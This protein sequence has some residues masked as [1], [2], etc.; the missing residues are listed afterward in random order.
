MVGFSVVSGVIGIAGTIYSVVRGETGSALS[1]SNAQLSN[2]IAEG[3]ESLEAG[4][5][6]LASDLDNLGQAEIATALRDVQDVA[7]ALAGLSG[8]PS[9][10]REDVVTDSRTALSNLLTQVNNFVTGAGERP[11][12]DNT[13][14][15]LV[16]V[17]YAATVHLEVVRLLDNSRY[18]LPANKELFGL[19]SQFFDPEGTDISAAVDVDN[20]D[21]TPDVNF[22]IDRNI[23]T[24][25]LEAIEREIDENLSVS[26]N[27]TDGD[28]GDHEYDNFQR[29]DNISAADDKDLAFSG[30][31]EYRSSP[32]ITGIESETYDEFVLIQ[33]DKKVFVEIGAMYH[34]L[35]IAEISAFFDANP[36]RPIAGS[37]DQPGSLRELV[38]IYRDGV[39]AGRPP[40]FS[41]RNALEVGDNIALAS[42]NL[43]QGPL[44]PS[45]AREIQ[46][47]SIIQQEELRILTEIFGPQDYSEFGNFAGLAAYFEEPGFEQLARLSEIYADLSD[48]E[49]VARSDGSQPDINGTDGNDYLV[50]DDLTTDDGAD[51]TLTGGAGEDALDAG[52]GNDDLSGEA[53]SD[54]LGGGTGSD[55]LFGGPGN[56]T[57]DGGPGSDTL[58]GGPGFDTAVLEAPLRAF[59]FVYAD[60]AIRE[61][62]VARAVDVG[63]PPAPMPPGDGDAEPTVTIF[64]TAYAEEDSTDGAFTV[65]LSEALDGPVEIGIDVANARDGAEFAASGADYTTLE[66]T[67][68]IPAGEVSAT[69]P[70]EV[71]ADQEPEA[72][73]EVQVTLDQVRSGGA[74]I[75]SAD[76]ATVL[77]G[78]D[79]LRPTELTSIEA[80]IFNGGEALIPVLRYLDGISLLEADSFLTAADDSLEGTADGEVLAGG[81]GRDTLDG[82]G[83]DDTLEGGTEDDE[84]DGGE[85]DDSLLGE[86]GDDSLTGGEGDDTLVPGPGDDVIAARGD[87]DALIR[88]DPGTDTVRLSGLPSDYTYL[89]ATNAALADAPDTDRFVLW[90]DGPDGQ[91]R[92]T[93]VERLVFTGNATVGDTD[94]DIAVDL[95]FRKLAGPDSLTGS[96]DADLIFGINADTTLEGGAGADTIFGSRFIDGTDIADETAD[97]IRGGAGNDLLI[98]G[99][100]GVSDP[101]GSDTIEG[102]TGEDTIDGGGGGDLLRGGE[103]ADLIDG[104]GSNDTLEGGAGNDTL[105]GGA[106]ADSLF[107]GAGDDVLEAAVGASE[108][109]GDPGEGLEGGAGNDTLTGSAGDDTLAGDDPDDPG[110]VK[111]DDR[112]FGGDGLDAAVFSGAPGDYAI[113]IMLGPEEEGGDP[114]RIE[115]TGAGTDTLESVETLIFQ[116]QGD[117]DGPVVIDDIAAVADTVSTAS[118][119]ISPLDAARAEGDEESSGFTFEVERGGNLLSSVNIG[120]DVDLAF[121]DVDRGDFVEGATSGRL[122]FDPGE[123]RKMVTIGVAA[124]RTEEND[125]FFEVSLRDPQ[126]NAE[127]GEGAAQGVILNDDG[128]LGTE[129]SVSGP[130]NR[131]EGDT[132]TEEFVFFVTRSGGTAQ[133]ATVDWS[134]PADAVDAADFGGTLP[135][136]T[137]TFVPGDEAETI[138]FDVAGDETPE[139]NEP[140]EVVLSNPSSGVRIGE[141]SA[142]G[143]II[144]DDGGS[145]SGADTQL[146]IAPEDAVRMEGNT[147]TTPF[148]FTVSRSGDTAGETSVDYAVSGFAPNDDDADAADFP[149]GVLPSGT[150]TFADDETEKTV[151]I[152][153]A[154]DTD[155]EEDETFVVNLSN[156]SAGTEIAGD[157]A[158]GTILDEDG[159]PPAEIAIIEFSSFEPEEGDAGTTEVTFVVQRSGTRDGEVSVDYA[160]AGGDVDAADFVGGRLPTGTLTFEDGGDLTKVFTVDVAGDITVEP[161]EDLTVVLSNPE[162]NA[163]ITRASRTKPLLNDDGGSGTPGEL[164]EGGP[165]GESLPGGDGDDTI[166]ARG[167]DDILDGGAGEDSMDGGDGFDTVVLEESL[168]DYDFAYSD[169]ARALVAEGPDETDLLDRVEEIVFD[170]GAGTEPVTRLVAAET[171]L[172]RPFQAG[173]DI[174]EV[175]FGAPGDD[176]SIL[177]TLGG[178]D[179]LDGRGGDDV[180]DGGQGEDELIGG[181]GNDILY[182]GEDADTFTVRPGDG[183]S[184]ILDFEDGVDLL[185]LTAF[186]QAEVSAV[187]DDIA[188]P[189]ATLTFLD[190]TTIRLD[191]LDPEDLGPEDLVSRAAPS[192]AELS[193]AAEA[194]EREEGDAGTTGFTFTV[195]RSGDTTG[196][197]SVD[198]AVGGAAVDGSDFD[199]GALPS[200]TVT[201]A[202]GETERSLTVAVAGDT[203]EEADEAFT[204]TL[205]NPSGAATIATA[206]ATGVIAN[207]DVE[208]DELSDRILRGTPRPDLQLGTAGATLLPD[209]GEDILLISDAAEPGILSVFEGQEGD[210]IQL[211]GGLEIASSL[212]VSNALQIE[213]TNGAR[214]QILEADQ[215]AYEIGANAVRNEAGR[216]VDIATFAQDLLGFA[217]SGTDLVEG[218]AVTVPQPTGLETDT[219]VTPPADT[220]GVLRGTDVADVLA[221]RSGTIYLGEDGDDTFI[222]SKAV[223]PGETSVIDGEAGDEVELI[224][225]LVIESA[226]VLPD[227]IELRLDSGAA[228]QILNANGLSYDIGGDS[229]RPVEGQVI[230]YRSFV[231]DV[232]RVDLP[233]SGSVIAGPVTIGAATLLLS[234][235]SGAEG[236]PGAP[237]GVVFTLALDQPALRDTTFAVA[238]ADGT[239]IAGEDYVAVDTTATIAAGETTVEVSVPF[240]GDTSVE[241]DETFDFVISSPGAPELGSV[242]LIGTIE[243]DDFVAV[244]VSDASVT[245]GAAGARLDFTVSLD[246]AAPEPVEVPVATADG[247]ATAGE[248]YT[249]LDTVVTIPAGQTSAAVSVEVL[250]D[251]LEEPDETVTLQLG[252][253]QNAAVADGTGTGTILDDEAPVTAVDGAGTYAAGPGP[254][255]FEIRID[256]SSPSAYTNPDFDGNVLIEGFDPGEDLLRFVE[257]SDTGTAVLSDFL[258]D[259]ATDAVEIV[260]NQITQS[261]SYVFA[262]DPRVPGNQGAIL[263]L[264]GVTAL[265]PDFLE[266][267]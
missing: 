11:T 35:D 50:G 194:A 109:T 234:D 115:V 110:G 12:V 252:D 66:P 144:D 53:G 61:T 73:E 85:G 213:L 161:D 166:E 118:L 131:F 186:P 191:G 135:S 138:R 64:A 74:T 126:G 238:T 190:R 17:A 192:G 241:A 31:I 49:F 41:V 99:P 123:T 23:R 81:G 112:I 143:V 205:S 181:P 13:L 261:L 251:A 229:T 90:L 218:G 44:A 207:D 154:G 29:A 97:V 77:I 104:R 160:V 132:G 7:Q 245:E 196:P 56:D 108:Q 46:R 211:P 156:P 224:V 5:D 180:L 107:G 24:V 52:P 215:Y 153:V 91:D 152:D 236:D 21:E 43:P 1:M 33:Y 96:G 47:F 212:Y 266:I 222:V 78:D 189:S 174:S 120:Y 57:L 26:V 216:A 235:E 140:F 151:T 168:E 145:A 175:S 257:V 127:I 259:M 178:D 2:Q 76:R 188:G 92:F 227:A 232:L 122:Y 36:A 176:E 195:I 83:G 94:D 203:V 198:Y 105:N 142:S 70:V 125:E 237:G 119:D 114:A 45:E 72:P 206:E 165:E 244:S 243:N 34:E 169:E 141:A 230:D 18:G 233:G 182:G 209:D 27:L 200:G 262:D 89:T 185:D 9:L 69:I 177:V 199:G 246:Q 171:V 98:G 214:Y 149:G 101:G 68:T 65:M 223:T 51:D 240:L 248:D 63:A 158:T 111:G 14:E 136:G 164:I 20:D 210:R 155:G 258:D 146:S 87:S 150:V 3:F 113:S 100:Q 75:G 157:R 86:P 217:L 19:V 4:I 39:E 265:S 25:L 172:I 95:L 163:V 197:A 106:G 103:D 187:L 264:D 193:I 80:L 263:E 10:T 221:V 121:S 60:P 42:Y 128:F 129:V 231:E 102:G 48:G 183:H 30:D 28:L 267:A 22:T 179:T 249:P 167:G 15:A 201:F 40:S 159:P 54:Y 220:R 124:D 184:R 117:P 134:V 253:P 247:T 147:G 84:L 37:V 208:R 226:L 219:P 173:L 71:L 116:N 170:G 59:D 88:P 250:D 58:H 137:V 62:V 242:T 225:G 93:G 204:V 139:P 38:E 55:E 67:V 202:D 133:E 162:G 239:A 255:V 8:D 6:G 148:S 32:S 79:D 260:L 82:L 130:F 256:S 254:E 228:V 16:A